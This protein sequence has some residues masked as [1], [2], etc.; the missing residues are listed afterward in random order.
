ML[1]VNA[2]AQGQK[3]NSKYS[4]TNNSRLSSSS[5]SS[6]EGHASSQHQTQSNSSSSTVTPVVDAN[7]KSPIVTNVNCTLSQDLP[8]SAMPTVSLKVF[9]KKRKSNVRSLIE[10]GSQRS[11]ISTTLVNKLKLPVVDTFPLSARIQCPPKWMW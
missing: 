11:F 4:S 5:S 1:C 8:T 7:A 6:N 2:A 10:S 3:T 9:A